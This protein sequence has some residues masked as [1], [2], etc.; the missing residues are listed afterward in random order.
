MLVISAKS[1]QLGNRLILFA[2]FI[3]FAIENKLTVLNPGFAEYAEYFQGTA[4]DLFCCYPPPLLKIPANRYWR[5]K[6]Y[7]FNCI[8]R[9]KQWFELEKIPRNKPFCWKYYQD[10]SRVKL[11]FF[12]GWLYREGWFVEDLKK[13]R[14]HRNQI[15][16]Y[17]KPMKRYQVNVNNLMSKLRTDANVVIIGVHIR[18]GDYQQHQDGRYFYTSEQYAEKMTSVK[19]LF[20][21]KQVKFLIC[22]N[23]EQDSKLFNKFEH[24]KGNNQLIEDMFSLSECDRIIG[25]PSTYTMFASFY[26][27][28]PLYM[29]RNVNKEISS[30]D[31]VI[32]DQWK[33][34][35]H[36]NDD[37]SKTYWEWTH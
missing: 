15:R 34:T 5:E 33:G 14:K 20:P 30:D 22:S 2:H 31:F 7:K 19:E 23:V 8:I 13:L 6:Y 36:Y 18:Q 3:S 16:E 1:G 21:D 35:F 26:G 37:W 10:N 24:V 32:F 29:I 12:T 25:P 9:D 4:T 11:V 17:L 27:D 28:I